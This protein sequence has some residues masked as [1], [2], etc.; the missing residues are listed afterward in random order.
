M[1]TTSPL[2]KLM[3]SM[4]FAVQIGSAVAA[5]PSSAAPVHPPMTGN[6]PPVAQ[7]PQEREGKV[8]VDPAAKF[9]HFR[10][11]NKNVKSIYLDGSVVWVGTSG[12]FVR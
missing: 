8:T 4:L 3:I 5:Q 9:T 7:Q 10:V 11:G 6:H 2:S 12:G 1:R